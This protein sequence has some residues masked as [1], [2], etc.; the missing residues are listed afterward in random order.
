[1]PPKKVAMHPKAA[2]AA[3]RRAEQDA[4]KVRKKAMEDERIEAEEWSVGAN[5]RAATR[6]KEKEDEAAAK[7]AKKAEMAAILKED[8]AT[9]PS[10]VGKK[11]KKKGKDDFDLLNAA[12][13]AAPK[14]KAQKQQELK[15]KQDE[16]RRQQEEEARARN[17]ERRQKEEE[18]RRKAAARGIALNH[19]DELMRENTNRQESSFEDVSG[20]E[21]AIDLMSTGEDID[22]HPERRQKALHNAYFE[23][24]LPIVK[25]EQPGLKLSQYKERIFE[26]WKVSP[27][28]PRYQQAVAAKSAKRE[29]GAK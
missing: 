6:R 22:A 9:H 17:E 21:A 23:K 20:V 7:A 25:H 28:N 8:E 2:A 27:E 11:P 26:M 14:T 18:E 5:D 12:L 10:T 24:M 19:G 3:D 4:D 16:Q 13:A 1:M 29:E 15:K